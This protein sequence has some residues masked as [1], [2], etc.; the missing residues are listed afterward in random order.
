V[1]AGFSNVFPSIDVRRRPSLEHLAIA[2]QL[3]RQHRDAFGVGQD[4][5]FDEA[6]FVIRNAYTGGSDHLKK[7]FDDA[8][9][10]RDD[11]YNTLCRRE[12]DYDRGDDFLQIGQYDMTVVRRC[13]LRRDRREQFCV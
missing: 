12:L 4:A 6:G 2:H 10:H 8:A 3:M 1:D 5:S 9:K 7:S 13:L 11:E